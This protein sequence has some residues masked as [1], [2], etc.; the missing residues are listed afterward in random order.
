MSARSVLVT[1]ASSGIGEATARRL[2]AAGWQVFAGVRD[3]A[4]AQ[5]LRGEHIEP[6][7]LD[8]TNAAHVAAAAER[9][10]RD[11]PAGLDGLVNN[12]GVAMSGPLEFFEV[13]RLREQLDINVVGLHAVTRALLPALRRTR[14][15]IVMIGSIG[16]RSVFPFLGPYSASKYAL[17]AYSDALRMELRSSGIR[18]VLLEPG[19]IKTP[20]WSKGARMNAGLLEALPEYGLAA[21]GPPLKKLGAM[22][23]KL[24]ADGLP[25][26]ACAALIERALTIPSPR[27]RYVLGSRA[28]VQSWLAR[29]PDGIKDSIF[30]GMLGLRP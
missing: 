12:A 17:E 18:V 1:G 10:E 8:V 28:K 22:N 15:R 24:D 6:L 19:S 16:G 2:A 30:T 4:A 3:D 26:E 13:E 20:I 11:L 25:P 5:R 14:G 27:A 29:L 9:V 21:Y 7:I 23:A